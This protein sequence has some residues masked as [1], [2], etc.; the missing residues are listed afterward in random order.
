MS[1]DRS[2]PKRVVRK[3]DR[4]IRDVRRYLRRRKV[5][6]SRACP[7]ADREIGFSPHMLV[8]HQDLLLAVCS[9]KALNL[10][11]NEALPWKFH[12]DG[13][14]TAADMQLVRSQFGG[15]RLIERAESDQWYEADHGVYPHLCAARKRAVMLLKLADVHVFSDKERIL[16]CDADLLFVRRPQFLV[17]RLMDAQCAN[18]FNRDID[19]H[20]ISPPNIIKELTG[21]APPE[22]IN[23]GLSILNRST[24]ALSRIERILQQ[25]DRRRRSDWF[26][27]DHLIEQTIVSLLAV[28]SEEGVAH[29]PPDYDVSLEKSIEDAV[30]KHYV[31]KIR[32]QYELEGLR[33]LLK[34]KDFAERWRAFTTRTPAW[35]GWRRPAIDIAR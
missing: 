8:C 6:L 12:D 16:Y 11:M 19:S 35:Q 24:I 22:R 9:A 32:E 23:A 31:I 33:Y 14:L 30:C 1:P 29:L 26:Y 34:E 21:I 25:L 17:D 4:S 13:S 7:H 20:Y 15:C 5:G 10:A 3:I 27:Y 2:F 18:Y 28:T